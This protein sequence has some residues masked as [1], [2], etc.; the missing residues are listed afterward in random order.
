VADITYNDSALVGYDTTFSAYPSDAEGNTHHEYI[1][2]TGAT[3]A[4]G[5]TA[6]G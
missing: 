3:G 6:E 5:E 2:A 4:T 1:K